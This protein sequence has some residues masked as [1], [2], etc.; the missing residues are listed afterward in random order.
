MEALDEQDWRRLTRSIGKGRCILLLGPDAATDAEDPEGIPLV[1][2]LAE[3]LAAGLNGLEVPD[4]GDLPSV[5][6]VYQDVN[7]R[8]ALEMAVEDF[9]RA[10][11]QRTTPLHT[12]L[13]ALPFSIYLNTAPDPALANAL[14]AA[15]RQPQVEH[16]DYKRSRDFTLAEPTAERPW[17]YDLY[18]NLA[19]PESLVL[20]E[21][22]LLDYLT[23]V[24][25]GTPRLPAAL[26]AR[27]RDPDTGLLFLCFGFRRWYL[28]ILLQ[29]LRADAKPNS[30][31]LAL[32]DSAFYSHP[33]GPR[34]L[35][36]FNRQHHIRFHQVACGGFVSELRV[37]FEAQSSPPA[38]PAPEPPADAPL[39]FLSYVTED[40]DAVETLAERLL[41]EGLRVWLDRQ[42]LRGGDRWGQLI[43]DV[44]GHQADYLLAIQTPRL[45]ART[46]SYVYREIEAALARQSGFAPGLRFLIPVV[47]D[48]GVRLP[49]LSHL[50]FVDLGLPQG[51]AAL[52]A[53]IRE[54]FHRRRTPPAEGKAP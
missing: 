32:E 53:G 6:Q 19:E 50:H 22:D 51:F 8:D 16:Y 48:G 18:G 31:F 17:V 37:R 38:A 5:A 7:G 52:V 10:Y 29:A 30:P 11:T 9:C 28:R 42:N 49:S 12:H 41:R 46:E 15:G 14:R 47:F 44:I 34:T 3:N 24:V 21:R 27:L 26:L 25:K 20:T 54:D 35:I 33:D 2:R 40:H 43:P 39:I 45:L 23:N 13:A 36:F 4:R 1:Q